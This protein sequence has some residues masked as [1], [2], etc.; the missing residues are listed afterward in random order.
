M[1][2]P[3]AISLGLLETHAVSWAAVGRRKRWAFLVL[4][5]QQVY[6]RSFFSRALYCL[7]SHAYAPIAQQVVS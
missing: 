4:A 3:S 7:R 6:A 2:F 1:L 5:L